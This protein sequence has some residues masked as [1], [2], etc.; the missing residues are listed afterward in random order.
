MSD[1]AT[2]AETPPAAL[3]GS[4]SGLDPLTAGREAAGPPPGLLDQFF[5]LFDAGGPILYVLAGLSVIAL[6][7]VIAKLLQFAARKVGDDGVVEPAL[8]ALAEG[9]EERVVEQMRGERSPVAAVV[10]AGARSFLI[11]NASRQDAEAEMTRVATGEIA[12]LSSGLR[13]LG[14]IATLSPLLGLLGTVIGMIDAFQ[15]LENAGSRVDPSVLS[16]GIWVALLTTA[17]G[18]VVAIPAAVAVNLL[19]GRVD[20]A[21]RR[22]EDAATRI[23]TIRAAASGGGRAARMAAE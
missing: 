5:S 13:V 10:G 11:P 1:D 4:A 12:E 16:G 3:D 22:M 7:I 21:A 6:T 18:L 19:D 8:R 2:A 15:A 20:R 23:L 17:A 14:L 9:G